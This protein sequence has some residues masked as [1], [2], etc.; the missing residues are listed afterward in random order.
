MKRHN[1]TFAIRNSPKYGKILYLLQISGHSLL[2][3]DLLGYMLMCLE[4][5][6]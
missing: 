1:G 2:Y 4:I 3:S 5:A 6:E